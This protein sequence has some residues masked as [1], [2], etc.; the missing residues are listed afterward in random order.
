[1][2]ERPD[3]LTCHRVLRRLA[4]VRIHQNVGI[5]RQHASPI[6]VDLGAE[7]LPGQVLERVWRALF[8]DRTVG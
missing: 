3:K 6:A 1:M 7:V 5:E 8:A 4:T 2:R